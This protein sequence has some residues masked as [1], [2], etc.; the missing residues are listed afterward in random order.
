[1]KVII[2]EKFDPSN[3]YFCVCAK[4]NEQSLYTRVFSFKHGEEP[5]SIFN[6]EKNYEDALAYAK[7]LEKFFTSGLPATKIVYENDIPQ[8]ED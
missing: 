2:E 1:M 5:V 7:E 3:P 6:R 4:L 8:K